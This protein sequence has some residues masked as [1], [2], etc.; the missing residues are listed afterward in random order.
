MGI[1]FN[2]HHRHHSEWPRALPI[3]DARNLL[4]ARWPDHLKRLL[5][6]DVQRVALRRHH[7]LFRAGER[8]D[9]VYFPESCLV[10]LVRRLQTGELLEIGAIGCD[11]MAGTAVFAGVSS[12]PCDG[13]TQIEGA[14]LRVSADAYR[15]HADTFPELRAVVDRSVL[16]L[17]ATS[18]QAALCVAFH[19]VRARCATWLLTA[20]DLTRTDEL[21]VTQYALAE[22]LGIQR[23]TVSLIVRS[24]A[25]R[26]CVESR[27]GHI[28]LVDR[29]ALASLACECYSVLKDERTR[30]LPPA[31]QAASFP[32]AVAL[33]S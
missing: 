22:L 7:P 2:E 31:V 28:R 15:R 14:A 12:M 25:A 10:S 32:R 13:V 9:A 1:A 3:D 27:R 29:P 4:V 11:N 16:V 18:M 19:T 26:G 5:A 30:L 8:L 17:Q 20:S 33:S 6:R 23:P 24:L 21:A